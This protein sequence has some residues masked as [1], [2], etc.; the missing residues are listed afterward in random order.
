MA[1][2]PTS[3]RAW[4][5]MQERTGQLGPLFLQLGKPALEGTQAKCINRWPHC[6]FV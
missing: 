5:G 4:A 6:P 3:T 2:H 1:C